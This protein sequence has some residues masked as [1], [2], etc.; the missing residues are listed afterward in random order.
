MSQA[1]LP[2]VA[3]LAGLALAASAG[4]RPDPLPDAV[5]RVRLGVGAIGSYNPA[6]RPPVEFSASGFFCFVRRRTLSSARYLI[7]PPTNMAK[8]V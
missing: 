1:R 4:E 6:D 8:V 2:W 3:I 5:A 7:S